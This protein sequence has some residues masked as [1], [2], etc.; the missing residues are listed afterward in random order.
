M[1][2]KSAC[3]GASGHIHF[4]LAE[5]NSEAVAEQI[6]HLTWEGEIERIRVTKAKVIGNLGGEG[7][8]PKWLGFLPK[9]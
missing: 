1:R 2:M 3:T 9:Y 5:R 4:S 8:T 7:S 6:S